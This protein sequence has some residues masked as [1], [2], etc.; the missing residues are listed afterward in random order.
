MVVPTRAM[1]RIIR[2]R[3]PQRYMPLAGVLVT[4]NARMLF[5]VVADDEVLTDW[6]SMPCCAGGGGRSSPSLRRPSGSDC[7]VRLCREDE[8]GVVRGR[9]G[10]IDDC[11]A[12]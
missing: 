11:R 9:T 1:R 10:E 5:G 3:T 7:H 8:I 12:R 4:K 6:T 2:G